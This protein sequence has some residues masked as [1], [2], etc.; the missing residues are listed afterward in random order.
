MY[1]NQSDFLQQGLYA[2]SAHEMLNITHSGGKELPGLK[3]RREQENAMFNNGG[4]DSTH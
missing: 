4:Y 1:P 2:E 3:K